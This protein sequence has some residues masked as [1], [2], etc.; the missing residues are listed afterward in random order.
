MG[1]MAY[2]VLNS[3]KIA[4]RAYI[5]SVIIFVCFQTLAAPIIIE[6]FRTAIA[7][8][9]VTLVFYIVKQHINLTFTLLVTSFFGVLKIA[10][11]FL[12]RTILIEF[13]INNAVRFFI[14][15]L[16]FEAFFYFF[17]QKLF[18]STAGFFS[19][20][21][22]DVRGVLFSLS[23]T[24]LALYG[25][26]QMYLPVTYTHD[27]S[28]TE[29][30]NLTLISV[31]LIAF[32]VNSLMYIHSQQKQRII[33]NE[34]SRALSNSLQD[35]VRRH[36]KYR[37]SVP[38]L[39]AAFQGLVNEVG[40]ILGVNENQQL[41][42]LD[43]YVDLINNLTEAIGDEF[44]NDDIEDEIK[45]LG[46]PD[47]YLDLGIRLGQLIM[48][49]REKGI[50]MFLQSRV[51]D[52]EDVPISNVELI[53]LVGNLL[54]NAIKE[55]SKTVIQ[56]KKVMIKFFNI[57][58]NFALSVR[59]NANEFPLEILKN[60][61]EKANTTNGSGFGYPEI[62]KLLYRENASFSIKEQRNGEQS[63]K[64]IT[65]IFDQLDKY[66][67]ESQ[68]RKEELHMALMGKGWQIL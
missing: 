50:D 60:L 19:S 21:T 10:A 12:A 62:C 17:A 11:I 13:N 25:V 67:I 31:S 3:K 64:I 8:G 2:D 47:D 37:D 20:N 46:L 59:D 23:A 18:K 56:S 52:W 41:Q 36:H 43:N 66:V 42:R 33:M 26:F 1:F 55:L 57:N 30:I 53:R 32:I 40:H 45:D 63:I 58:G 65:V 44:S 35:I 16:T 68:Y 54:D 7:I 51:E 15:A 24:C 49:A 48:F 34:K 9:L 22:S 14:L 5:P 38:T 39:L 61:G 6:P 27:L 29:L 28:I 4:P